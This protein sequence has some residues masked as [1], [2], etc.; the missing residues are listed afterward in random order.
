MIGKNWMKGLAVAG[1]AAVA[2]AAVPV[3]SNAST[4]YTGKKPATIAMMEAAGVTPLKKVSSRHV[5][6]KHVLHH[7]A[8]K[9]AVVHSKLHKKHLTLTA[10]KKHTV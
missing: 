10:K 3:V 5:V 7:T 2:A 4:H 6:T 9:K 1:V 8:I